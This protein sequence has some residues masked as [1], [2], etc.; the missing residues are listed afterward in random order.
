MRYSFVGLVFLVCIGINSCKSKKNTNEKEVLVSENPTAEKTKGFISH[1]YKNTNCST[2]IIVPMQDAD[3]LVLWPN[4]SIG[5]FDV[6][7]EWIKFNYLPLKMASPEA[8]PH[9]IPASISDLEK[10]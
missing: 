6:E 3:T 2:L 7:G 8:C 5:K 1:K 9:A 10:I 4:S